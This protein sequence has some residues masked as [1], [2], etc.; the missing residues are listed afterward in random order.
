MNNRNRPVSSSGDNIPVPYRCPLC[1]VPGPYFLTVEAAPAATL[2]STA[3]GEKSDTPKLKFKLLGAR[4]VLGGGG[5]GSGGVQVD[6]AHANDDFLAAGSSGSNTA[7]RGAGYPRMSE[8]RAAV[9]TQLALAAAVSAADAERE[10]EL[11]GNGD[12]ER[13]DKREGT[14]PPQS[15]SLSGDRGSPPAQSSGNGEGSGGHCC[16]ARSPHTGEG[17]PCGARRSSSIGT[18]MPL[19]PPVR[20]TA[21]V[22]R[23]Q[24]YSSSE[25]IRRGQKQEQQQQRRGRR[26]P[27]DDSA[28]SRSDNAS[29]SDIDTPAGERRREQQQGHQG[30]VAGAERSEGPSFLEE[31]LFFSRAESARRRCGQQRRKRR[32]RPRRG[33]DEGHKKQKEEDEVKWRQ[34]YHRREVGSATEGRTK[35]GRGVHSCFGAIDEL[36]W[37]P[38]S[39][40]AEDALRTVETMLKREKERLGV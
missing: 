16:S 31:G 25:L 11:K 19:T 24:I 10:K 14:K 35:A 32:S 2:S 38:G 22:E 17:G 30:V 9:R 1:Q 5:P 7:R 37:E 15:S 40:A 33:E 8:L 39:M 23:C 34:R 27:D 36:P 3:V 28:R 20:R 18:F 4:T 12:G 6:T 13:D 29:Y 21:S 26:R